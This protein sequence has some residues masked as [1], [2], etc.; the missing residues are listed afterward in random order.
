M[1]SWLSYWN[2]RWRQKKISLYYFM[3]FRL[4]A[5]TWKITCFLFWNLLYDHEIYRNKYYDTPKLFLPKNIYALAW[6]TWTSGINNDAMNYWNL[7]WASFKELEDFFTKWNP[8]IACSK[9]KLITKISMKDYYRITIFSQENSRRYMWTY[10]STMQTFWIF[11]GI[12]W[13]IK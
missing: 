11:Y 7:T 10:S 2:N 9:G 12:D 13:C 3:Y 5:C 1:C 8:C 6:L 4:E